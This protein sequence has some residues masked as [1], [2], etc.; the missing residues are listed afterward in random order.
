VKNAP[1]FHGLC[2]MVSAT[3]AGIFAGVEVIV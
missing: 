2:A 1:Q 3:G